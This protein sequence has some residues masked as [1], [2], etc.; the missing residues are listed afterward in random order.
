MIQNQEGDSHVGNELK[1]GRGIQLISVLGVLSPIGRGRRHLSF[2]PEFAELVVISNSVVHRFC[3]HPAT[4]TELAVEFA[5]GWALT[6][7]MY[8]NLNM[9]AQSSR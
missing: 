1:K 2:A 5:N 6:Y 8:G 9:P 3:S 4:F 7:S